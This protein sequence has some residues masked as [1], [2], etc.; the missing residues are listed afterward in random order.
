VLHVG[1]QQY[2]KCHCRVV[3]VHTALSHSGY[4]PTGLS[5]L[6]YGSK[7]F[8]A[9]MISNWKKLDFEESRILL[10]IMFFPKLCTVAIIRRLC[11]NPASFI[12]KVTIRIPLLLFCMINIIKLSIGYRDRALRFVRKS[13]SENGK[14]RG[15]NM[16]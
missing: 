3:Q 10:K 14:S 2:E 4:M 13:K 15:P 6:L 12:M 7:T 5:T 11:F 8:G 9:D 16:R 1:N